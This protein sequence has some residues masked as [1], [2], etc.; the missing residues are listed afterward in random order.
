[1]IAT[2]STP[3][4]SKSVAFAVIICIF[5]SRLVPHNNKSTSRRSRS[6]ARCKA[7]QK[8]PN[9]P[10]TLTENCLQT[11]KLTAISLC[12]QHENMAQATEPERCLT[13]LAA[14]TTYVNAKAT[15]QILRG[16]R[17]GPGPNAPT[18][19]LRGPDAAETTSKVIS[20]HRA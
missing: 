16:A 4:I 5:S 9:Q 7:L 20:L 12:K 3:S 13:D 8:N 15:R 2:G 6:E 10:L 14:D 18:W 1:M 11:V 17:Q 19:N